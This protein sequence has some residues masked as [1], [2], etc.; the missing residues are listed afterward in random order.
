[1]KKHILSMIIL[2]LS[3]AACTTPAD[4]TLSHSPTRTFSLSPTPASTL[5]IC[6]SPTS[7]PEPTPE[8]AP[9]FVPDTDIP[10]IFKSTNEPVAN[11]NYTLYE[12]RNYIYYLNCNDTTDR[13]LF[14]IDKQTRSVKQITSKDCNCFTINNGIIYYTEL[15]EPNEG[16]WN[17][18]K[19]YNTLTNKKKTIK[20]LNYSV[21]SMA[22]YNDTMYFSYFT[23]NSESSVS[24]L[25]VMNY[26]GDSKKRIAKDAYTFCIYKDVIYYTGSSYPDYPPIDKVNLDGSGWEQC[27]EWADWNFYASD[28]K[29][30][31]NS[32]YTD[33]NNGEFNDMLYNGFVPFGKYLIYDNYTS[34]GNKDTCSFYLYDFENGNTKQ[35]TQIEDIDEYSTDTLHSTNENIYF[36]TANDDGSF[37]LY[38]LV[39]EKGKASMELVASYNTS[40]TTSPS[41]T[42]TA[43]SELLPTSEPMPAP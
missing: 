2:L 12:D 25:Y 13:Y 11:S 35:L 22:A 24:N 31:Y 17:V 40:P 14:C 28:N 9:A 37:K 39:I 32:G 42:D 4:A 43:E 16:Y 7:T 6:P 27:I 30:F 23:D 1:M 10:D 29:L 38:R 26:D 41:P 19:S 20:C 33:L 21:A 8:P 18:I 5:T 15:S 3:L 36:S 34:T